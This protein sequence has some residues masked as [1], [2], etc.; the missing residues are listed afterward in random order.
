MILG[1]GFGGLA[2]AR[3]LDEAPVRVTLVD[4][5]NHHLF[6]PLLY[7]VATAGLSPAEIASPIRQILG[8]QRNAEVFLA[9]A[10]AVDVGGRRVLLA[11]GV[12]AYDFLIVATGVS[13]SYFG[14]DEWARHAPG[15]KTLADALEIRRR[16]LLAYE[17]AEREPDPEKRRP[18][19]TFVVVGAGPTGVEMA[20][21][22][23]EIARHTLARDFRHI[24]PQGAR[25]ILVEAG[26]RVLPAYPSDLS[27]KAARQL[28]G[29]G[30]QVWRGV[31]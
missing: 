22:L 27:D 21:A 16:V 9:E 26:P 12:I 17:Q 10:T 23:A 6:Q 2:A 3:A 8:R 14:R 29:L 25:V 11:D 4:R 13:H 7:Q 31:R 24:D 15:L 28:E 5:Q 20:G 19:L 1:G 18:C 30:V